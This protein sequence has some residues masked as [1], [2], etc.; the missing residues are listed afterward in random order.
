MPTSRPLRIA[1]A[2]SLLAGGCAFDE[3]Y[4]ASSD[5]GGG[6]P[7]SG[8]DAGPAS[9][10]GTPPDGGDPDRERYE[11]VGSN[12]YVMAAHD[13]FSTFAADVDT[14]SYDIFVRD[15]TNGRLPDPASVRLE[16][17]VNAFDYDY[18]TPE[19]D[20]EIPFAID[21]VAAQHPLRSGIAQLRIGIQA[22]R[23]PEFEQ[24][25]TN[26][27]FL[28]DTSGSMDSS[29][30]LPLAQMV[31][32]ETIPTLN[33]T[34]TIS[35]VTYGPNTRVV[36]G[37][38]RASDRDTI[39]RAIDGLSAS[40]G[41]DG[42]RGIQMAYEQA[43]AGFISDGFNHV[44]LM[45]DGDFNI[46]ITDTADLVALIE[47]E[48]ETGV[49]LTALGFGSDNLNDAMM[50]RVSN[51]GNGVYSVITSADHARRYAQED[52][53]HTAHFVAQD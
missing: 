13:P 16:E 18:P 29:E 25:A 4:Y 30:K 2:C 39:V 37:P 47:R 35:I 50:E 34:D 41:T 48:R 45:T 43:R 15:A 49:T 19:V 38:T 40:G 22:S 36:L 27:V 53:L 14:A 42:G 11:D 24:L 5:A 1:L 44:V 12:P 21:L 51:S 3:G 31:V 23:P 20:A 52:I 46:G 8:F 7:M 9:D 6:R 32:R 17:Y 26:L 28:V 33:G 10:A